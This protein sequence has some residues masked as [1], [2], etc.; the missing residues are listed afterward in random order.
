MLSKLSRAAGI[1]QTPGRVEQTR[2]DTSALK[3]F[4][5]AFIPPWSLRR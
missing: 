4:S 3:R 2:E 1:D 5:R